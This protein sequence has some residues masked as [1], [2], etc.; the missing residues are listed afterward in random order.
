MVVA[1]FT[2]YTHHA[3]REVVVDDLVGV[4]GRAQIVLVAYG[5]G[6]S[7]RVI[8]EICQHRSVAYGT[9]WRSLAKKQAIGTF[10][11]IHPGDDIAV[12]WKITLKE[13]EA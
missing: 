1:L 11:N 3:D 13:V 7:L 4:K 2:V 8:P 9:A 5:R 10:Y 6:Y 12:R